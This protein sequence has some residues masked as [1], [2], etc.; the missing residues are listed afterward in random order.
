M[1][2]LGG[3]FT[4]GLDSLPRMQPGQEKHGQRLTSLARNQVGQRNPVGQPGQ[5]GP[6]RDRGNAS[7]LGVG[8]Y[9]NHL[10]PRQHWP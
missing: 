7:L 9:E 2:E 6:R 5:P 8:Q 1:R 10:G 3:H 4:E